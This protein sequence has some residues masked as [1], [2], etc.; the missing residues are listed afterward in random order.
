MRLSVFCGL[1]SQALL[2]FY[3]TISTGLYLGQRFSRPNHHKKKEKNCQDA[4]KSV[5][6]AP[7]AV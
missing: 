7:E 6:P 5:E 3:A 2:L 4:L 1:P